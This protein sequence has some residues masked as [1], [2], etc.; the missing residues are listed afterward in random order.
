MWNT[1]K[2]I[3]EDLSSITINIDTKLYKNISHFTPY[4][5]DLELVDADEP[6]SKKRSKYTISNH[7]VSTFKVCQLEPSSHLDFPFFFSQL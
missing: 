6:E 3:S 2:D 7:T 1:P 5:P 4:K